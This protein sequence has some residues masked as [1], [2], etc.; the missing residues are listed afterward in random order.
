MRLDEGLGRERGR[1]WGLLLGRVGL[2]DG[3]CGRE[4]GIRLRREGFAGGVGVDGG[5]RWTGR[6]C[7]CYCRW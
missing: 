7:L 2:G 1:V 3:R 5:K 4:G 6:G